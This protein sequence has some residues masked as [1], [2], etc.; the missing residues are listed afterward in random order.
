MNP[1]PVR[2]DAKTYSGG[3]TLN[4]EQQIDNNSSA[5]TNSVYY[6]NYNLWVW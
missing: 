4:I 5:G 1:D 3:E 2:C 6:D